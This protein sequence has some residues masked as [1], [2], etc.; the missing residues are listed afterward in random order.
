MRFSVGILDSLFG[1]RITLE[2]ADEKGT[3][4]KREVTK[5][6]LEKME[7]EG[8]M[9]TINKPLIKVHMLHVL[10]GYKVLY[11]TI[12]EDIDENTVHKYKD[13]K[14]DDIYATTYFENGDPRVMVLN[15]QLWEDARTK[16]E[17]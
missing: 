9:S 7:Q 13:P 1:K 16:M 3:I 2:T 6:W 17:L 4:I 11:W 10:N 15:K 14:T 5:K 8:K 12:G